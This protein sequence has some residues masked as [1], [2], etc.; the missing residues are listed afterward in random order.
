[1]NKSLKFHIKPKVDIACDKFNLNLGKYLIPIMILV[2][3]LKRIRKNII[4]LDNSF[5]VIN[6][7]LLLYIQVIY[8]QDVIVSIDI[9]NTFVGGKDMTQ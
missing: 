4:T 3:Y 7:V 5:P 9:S 1:M 2:N 8:V 6:W